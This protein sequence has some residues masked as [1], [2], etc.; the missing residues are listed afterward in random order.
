MAGTA[1]ALAGEL[2]VALAKGAEDGSATLSR[3]MAPMVETIHEP[4][5]PS[6]GTF[7]REVLERHRVSERAMFLRV[8][9]DFPESSTASSP[10]DSTVVVESRW[11]GTLPD[12]RP[13]SATVR[14]VYSVSQGEV[15]AVRAAIDPELIATLRAALAEAGLDASLPACDRA[16][17][18]TSREAFS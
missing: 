2:N 11:S 17:G 4:P 10:D 9:P 12:G 6:D 5:L 3:W 16:N 8:I 7:D 1:A 14:A 13:L 15:V 18:E